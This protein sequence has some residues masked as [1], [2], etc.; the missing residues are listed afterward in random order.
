VTPLGR[1]L[2]II[3]IIIIIN[4]LT[5]CIRVLSE[6]LT[7]RQLVKKFPALYG[8]RRFITAF[9]SSCQLSPSWT[10]SI[11]PMPPHFTSGRSI[12]VL[13][14][15]LRLGLSSG[16]FP[17]VSPPNPVCTFPVPIHTTYIHVP[18]GIRTHPSERPQTYALHRASTGVGQKWNDV[19]VKWPN[20]SI[21]QV[22]RQRL[23]SPSGTISE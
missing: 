15:H 18:D 10:R 2:I 8:T 23:L 11:Q 5:P 4:W 12:L 17:Q 21:T 7:G 22:C 1:R 13:S 6:K 16:S 3:I 14:S 9:T 20:F 19:G